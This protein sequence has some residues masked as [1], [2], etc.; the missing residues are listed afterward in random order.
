[1]T[2]ISAVGTLLGGLVFIWAL[3]I[4]TLLVFGSLLGK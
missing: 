4:G 3:I 2:F 1:V